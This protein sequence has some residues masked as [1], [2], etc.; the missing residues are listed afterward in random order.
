[1]RI[2]FSFQTLPVEMLPDLPADLRI[3]HSTETLTVGPL[4]GWDDPASFWQ[5]RRSFWRSTPVFDMPDGE[6][7]DAEPWIP[8]N[9]QASRFLLELVKK[10]P[11]IED[12]WPFA[13][14]E[15]MEEVVQQADTIEVW[16]SS[17]ADETLGL[18]RLLED[19][20]RL[21][22]DPAAL[23]IRS[24]KKQLRTFE[25][26]AL[27]LQL[28]GGRQDCPVPAR[29]VSPEEQEKMRSLGRAAA[30]LPQN[31][32]GAWR[33]DPDAAGVFSVLR[34]RIPDPATGL[35]NIRSRLLSAAQSRWMKM[36]RVVGDAMVKGWDDADQL[37]VGILQMELEAM[38]QL[39]LPLVEITGQGAMRHCEVRLTEQG[40][41]LKARLAGAG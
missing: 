40:N 6:K 34:G 29:L 8:I 41:V 20:S 3:F 16:S 13:E 4:A 33:T 37:N 38:A 19:V 36:T 11:P 39:E 26:Q 22:S 9:P 7:W 10:G 31:W 23:R 28:I 1:M 27:W 2:I 5:A 30:G 32:P 35:T 17:S 14:P 25:D 15:P 21:R 12:D 24:F 18:W